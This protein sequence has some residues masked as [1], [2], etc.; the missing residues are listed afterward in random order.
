MSFRA[1][2]LSVCVLIKKNFIICFYNLTSSC[3]SRGCSNCSKLCNTFCNLGNITQALPKKGSYKGQLSQN[4]KLVWETW[5]KSFEQAPVQKSG[6]FEQF[7]Q[8]KA[9]F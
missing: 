2:Y 1:K 7:E 6:S 8:R 4:E 3:S 9:K 5:E